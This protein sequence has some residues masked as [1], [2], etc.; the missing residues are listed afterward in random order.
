MNYTNVIEATEPNCKMFFL[1]GSQ[2]KMLTAKFHMVILPFQLKTMFVCMLY[3]M[4]KI[5]AI[6]AEN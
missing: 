3:S 4:H 2:E 1:L 5:Y 6:I